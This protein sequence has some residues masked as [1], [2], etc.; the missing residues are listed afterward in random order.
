MIVFILA[1]LVHLEEIRLFIEPSSFLC[2]F[3]FICFSYNIFVLIFKLSHS[4]ATLSSFPISFLICP[5]RIHSSKIIIVTDLLLFFWLFRSDRN[6]ATQDGKQCKIEH[7]IF[8]EELL[9]LISVEFEESQSF[10]FPGAIL[11]SWLFVLST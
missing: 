6:C 11:F 8:H 2:S 10:N 7:I 4:K 9:L 3:F 5:L 1:M